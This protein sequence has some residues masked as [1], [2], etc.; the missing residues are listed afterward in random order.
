MMVTS[1]WA[2]T[3]FTADNG[4]TRFVPGSHRFPCTP[5]SPDAPLDV[6]VCALEM[7][8]G[9]VMVFHGSL[10]HGGRRELTADD[11]RLGVNVQYCPG[12]VRQQQN[13]YLGIPPE[14]AATFSDRL[15]E[16]LGYRLYKGIM[17]H[18]DGASPGEVVF[19]E[20]MAQTAY[21]ERRAPA[22]ES[23]AGARTRRLRCVVRRSAGARCSRVGSRACRSSTSSAIARR[24]GRAVAPSAL[25]APRAASWSGSVPPI[26]SRSPPAGE[27]SIVPAAGL[28]RSGRCA[29]A[30]LQQPRPP[31]AERQDRDHGVLAVA[32]IGVAVRG[33]AVATVAV[34]REPDAA[35]RHAVLVLD[36]AV[37]GGERRVRVRR[38]ARVPAAHARLVEVALVAEHATLTP[39]HRLDELLV[40]RRRRRAASRA[41]R[42]PTTRRRAGA[43][44]GPHRDRCAM[45]SAIALRLEAA[46]PRAAQRPAPPASRSHDVRGDI[47]GCR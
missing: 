35:E 13:P 42:R 40:E 29:A 17:G 15:L 34:E 2:L 31:R 39:R 23:T 47:D 5:E 44:R 21:D 19:G 30:W 41:S 3:D 20:R 16:L 27:R 26:T 8:A 10:W 25:S 43:A 24:S 4:G 11:R 18:V 12:F 14:I 38:V 45:S 7:P 1:M 37:R 46:E 32:Q 33:D 9:S 28:R 22:R 6:D 36:G